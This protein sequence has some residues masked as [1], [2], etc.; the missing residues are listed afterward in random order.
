MTTKK[1]SVGGMS[2]A[3][4]QAAVE[5]C[6]LSLDGIEEVSVSLMTNSMTLTYDENKLAE[7]NRYKHA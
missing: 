3:A 6:V 2:C 1:Y 7:E 5:K 4:C